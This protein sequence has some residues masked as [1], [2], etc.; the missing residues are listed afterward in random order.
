MIHNVI[1]PSTQETSAEAQQL[2]SFL[3]Q[4]KTILSQ[5]KVT[6][7]DSVKSIECLKRASKVLINN[8]RQELWSIFLQF[9][10]D[11]E[12][13]ICV[14]NKAL[15]G[16]LLIDTDLLLKQTVFLYNV[17]RAIVKKYK[18]YFAVQEFEGIFKTPHLYKLYERVLKVNQ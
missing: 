17:L 10:R 15:L 11:N 6:R 13:T 3:T 9:H 8:P 16:A 5:K 4:Y 18:R 7:A 1:R 2:I 14:E 12:N